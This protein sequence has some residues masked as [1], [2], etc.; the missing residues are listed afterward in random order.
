MICRE[1]SAKRILRTLSVKLLHCILGSLMHSRISIRADAVK[2]VATILAVDP[3]VMN[4]PIVKSSVEA[5]LS[6]KSIKVR[7]AV[8]GLVGKHI[9]AR[10]SLAS[11][12]YEIVR[13]RLLDKGV[14]V[15]KQAVKILRN[16]MISQPKHPKRVDTCKYLLNLY[17]DKILCSEKSLRVIV[18]ETLWKVWFESDDGDKDGVKDLA[19]EFVAITERSSTQL[20]SIFKTFWEKVHEDGAHAEEENDRME[21]NKIVSQT[22]AIVKSLVGLLLD[23]EELVGTS[24]DVVAAAERL[25]GTLRTLLVFA[26]LDPAL[27]VPHF[28]TISLHLKPDPHLDSSPKVKSDRVLIYAAKIVCLVVSHLSNPSREMIRGLLNDLRDVI[29]RREP[30]VVEVYVECLSATC[31]V[32]GKKGRAEILEIVRRMYRYLHDRRAVPSLRDLGRRVLNSIERAL[33]TV[34]VICRYVDFD[35]NEKMSDAEQEDSKTKLDSLIGLTMS[36][37]EKKKE[38]TRKNVYESFYNV[39]CDFASKPYLPVSGQALSAICS[40]CSRR[41]KF[42]LR[43]ETQSFLRRSLSSQNQSVVGVAIEA[44]C[45]MLEADEA[46]IRKQRQRAARPSVLSVK[47][48][49]TMMTP[50]EALRAQGVSYIDQVSADQT[51]ESGMIIGALQPHQDQIETL[52]WHDTSSIRT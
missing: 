19:L 24:Q 10:Q 48:S 9:L 2:A 21:D 50:V 36:Q 33:F 37:F 13:A 15:R 3:D 38:L 47:N 14:S 20:L 31:E 27:L 26:E 1:D 17:D 7:E 51:P 52:L 46:R 29:F 32:I 41:P 5:R 18:Q 45:M 11:G 39:C 12:Y 28:E 40:L 34:G 4:R 8:L 42:A 6:D 25:T 16:I 44:L 43:R 35:D 30:H 23:S 49:T 22:R